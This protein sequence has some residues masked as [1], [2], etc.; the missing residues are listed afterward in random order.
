MIQQGTID[1]VDID[2]DLEI[3]TR[4]SK[5]QEEEVQSE[6]ERSTDDDEEE[7]SSSG[8][9]CLPFPKACYDPHTNQLMT[10]PVVAPDGSSHEKNT[11]QEDLEA[12]SGDSDV[13]D[14]PNRAL[15]SY[16]QQ[17]QQHV[18][19]E[20]S[21][22]L[23]WSNTMRTGW[24]HFVEGGDHPPALPGALYCPISHDLLHE[25]VI[26]PGGITYEKAAILYW[27]QNQQ[28]SP[29]TRQPLTV[30][31]LRDNH[32][33]V[34]VLEELANGDTQDNPIHPVLQQ[35]KTEH[36]T[37][38]AAPPPPPTTHSRTTAITTRTYPAN[39]EELRVA[40]GRRRKRERVLWVLIAL[41]AIVCFTFPSFLT[42]CVVL[43]FI[44]LAFVKSSWRP[45]YETREWSGADPL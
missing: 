3:E 37:W 45:L 41:V 42:L 31:Q 4:S 43:A 36:A 9:S 38:P 14:Y 23:H 39:Y 6:T 35:W 17:Q 13:R 32:A 12:S 18:S 25:A 5:E 15:Q 1:D 24:K 27:L 28:E 29:V 20:S 11:E 33:I 8:D 40:D 34:S 16:I 19:M 44:V 2:I 21:V 7:E 30:D 22:L 26:E 10:N